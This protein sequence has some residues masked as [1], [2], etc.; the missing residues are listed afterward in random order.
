MS[1]ST[2]VSFCEPSADVSSIFSTYCSIIWQCVFSRDAITGLFK[3]ADPVPLFVIDIT[4][5]LSKSVI[6]SLESTFE[7]FVL[8]ILC[9]TATSDKSCSYKELGWDEGN[10]VG[11]YKS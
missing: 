11:M 1:C 2:R 10:V 5:A 4:M 3:I 6:S 8:V 7:L 9:V